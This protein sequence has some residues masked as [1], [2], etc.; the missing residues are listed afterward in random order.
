MPTATVDLSCITADKVRRIAPGFKDDAAI[1][2]L[3]ALG[4]A[5]APR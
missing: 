1:D 5:G 2:E 3:L 4:T